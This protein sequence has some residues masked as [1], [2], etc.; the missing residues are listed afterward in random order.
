[1]GPRE[2][3]RSSAMNAV[4]QLHLPSFPV[5]D[6]LPGD[7]P[8]I[9]CKNVMYCICLKDDRRTTLTEIEGAW[10]LCWLVQARLSLVFSV[11]AVSAML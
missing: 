1:M 11:L 3:R 7:S 2:A 10:V 9:A 8:P 5:A 6:D 4:F